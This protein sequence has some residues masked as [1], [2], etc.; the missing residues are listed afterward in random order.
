MVTSC[1]RCRMRYEGT[2]VL[3]IQYNQ[4]AKCSPSHIPATETVAHLPG[5]L[6]HR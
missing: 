4:L 6:R 5:S 2:F 3:E 1:P